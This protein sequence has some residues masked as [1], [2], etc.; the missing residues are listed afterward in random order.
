MSDID[1]WYRVLDGIASYLYRSIATVISV[2]HSVVFIK[3]I[4]KWCFFVNRRFANIV[5]RYLS[6]IKLSAG[7][8]RGTPSSILIRCRARYRP[9]IIPISTDKHRHDD[10]PIAI[11]F[12][13]RRVFDLSHNLK[14]DDYVIW[15]MLYC[16]IPCSLNKIIRVRVIIT[17]GLTKRRTDIFFNICARYLGETKMW[18]L[19]WAFPK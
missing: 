5:S 14:V 19:L 8:S 1:G 15:N 18:I 4:S 7:W 2:Q 17:A 13:L 9:G 3:A 12:H 6:D 11:S 10:P 16:I